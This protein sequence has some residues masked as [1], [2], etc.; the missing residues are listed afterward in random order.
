MRRRERPLF[1]RL[2]Q[3]RLHRVELDVI[4]DAFQLVRVEHAMVVRF[5]LPEWPVSCKDTV[6]LPSGAYF[7]R[8]HDPFP[9]RPLVRTGCWTI[10]SSLQW[11]EYPMQVAGH[12]HI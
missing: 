1:W 7:E 3:P 2:N 6:A 10:A 9:G 11:L 8:V 12:H 5:R 4:D